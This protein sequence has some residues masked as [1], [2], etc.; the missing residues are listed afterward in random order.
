MCFRSFSIDCA[1]SFARQT[2]QPAVF[3]SSLR[4]VEY[5]LA[6]QI[7][8]PIGEAVKVEIGECALKRRHP[9]LISLIYVCMFFFFYDY[10]NYNQP[11]YIYSSQFWS[12]WAYQR[13]K[14]KTDFLYQSINQSIR[15]YLFLL[16]IQWPTL[17]PSVVMSVMVCFSVSVSVN[18]H[19]MF[20]I[21]DWVSQYSIL[22]YSILLCIFLGSNFTKPCQ[23][24]VP[25]KGKPDVI[26]IWQVNGNFLW[27]T[28]PSARLHATETRSALLTF[29]RLSTFLFLFMLLSYMDNICYWKYIHLVSHAYPDRQRKMLCAHGKFEMT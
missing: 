2:N 29:L 5:S 7:R 12:L 22:F 27:N 3:V 16:Y 15:D 19:W 13:K 17:P 28:K 4:P 14:Q 20:L 10:W 25:C 21:S 9:F 26:L 23:V 1:C 24:F 18:C 6:P 11:R 8:E